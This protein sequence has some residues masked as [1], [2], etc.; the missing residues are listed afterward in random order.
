MRASAKAGGTWVLLVA[1]GLASHGVFAF[2]KALRH[3]CARVRTFDAAH[4]QEASSLE[5]LAGSVGTGSFRERSRGYA[6]LGEANP[7]EVLAVLRLLSPREQWTIKCLTSQYG[8]CITSLRMALASV[9]AEQ[10]LPDTPEDAASTANNLAIAAISQ[11]KQLHQEDAH[12]GSL[13][14]QQQ[15][16]TEPAT[17]SS[18]FQ[19]ADPLAAEAVAAATPENVVQREQALGHEMQ[20]DRRKE[21]SPSEH[22]QTPSNGH[23]ERTQSV[24]MDDQD[25]ALLDSELNCDH[26]DRVMDPDNPPTSAHIPLVQGSLA[27]SQR[28]GI[29]DDVAG[30]LVDNLSPV[31]L[32]NNT[33]MSAYP[34]E[35]LSPT[36]AGGNGTISVEADV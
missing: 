2:T 32:Q 5:L 19:W 31:T 27:S 12:C 3:A 25:T 6:A 36:F 24:S 8:H 16:S 4:V 20:L 7:Q 11:Q 15:Q 23:H 33:L 17:D 22:K 28:Q 26:R 14:Q 18:E 21:D 35:P 34:D 1:A 29:E 30:L 9:V 13:A 10:P